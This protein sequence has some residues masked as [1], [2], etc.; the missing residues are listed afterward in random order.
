MPKEQIGIRIEQQILD[1]L[2]EEAT[3]KGITISLLVS[4]VLE[5]YYGQETDKGKRRL[6]N[7]RYVSKT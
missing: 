5:E 1:K 6:S 3:D 7:Y 2:K 4:N